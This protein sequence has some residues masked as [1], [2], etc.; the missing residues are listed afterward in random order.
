MSE[1]NEVII[2]NIIQHLF[3]Q[4]SNLVDKVNHLQD[5]IVFLEHN[6]GNDLFTTSDLIDISNIDIHNLT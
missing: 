5:R 3:I 2:M 6:L 1:Y 4:N